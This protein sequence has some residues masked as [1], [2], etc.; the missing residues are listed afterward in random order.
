MRNSRKNLTVCCASTSTISSNTSLAFI[1]DQD[2]RFP[3]GIR[4]WADYCGGYDVPD[5]PIE[6]ARL[7]AEIAA[8]VR[9]RTHTRNTFDE[10]RTGLES[11]EILP[12]DI[13]L[14]PQP[15]DKDVWRVPCWVS[16]PSLL[17]GKQF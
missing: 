17:Q 3:E 1:D 8:S 14:Q 15:T 4:R 10:A 5:N 13:M 6:E 2:D 7:L 12:K 9:L 11:S 16:F